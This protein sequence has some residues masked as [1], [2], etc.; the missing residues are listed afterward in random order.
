MF[1]NLTEY[2]KKTVKKKVFNDKNLLGLIT[3]N[4]NVK[5]TLFFSMASKEI[6]VSVKSVTISKIPESKNERIWL[7][8]LEGSLPH[9]ESKESASDHIYLDNLNN[10]LSFF[11]HLLFKVKS[12]KLNDEQI[13]KIQ[14]FV[15]EAGIRFLDRGSAVS[16]R[17]NVLSF[18]AL[19]IAFS[20][21][22]AAAKSM[23]GENLNF[24]NNST[25]FIFT[26]SFLLYFGALIRFNNPFNLAK[27]TELRHLIIE[28]QLRIFKETLKQSSHA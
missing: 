20:G 26:S 7:S 2:K 16:S 21:F 3:D 23:E 11:K 17:K 12:E 4:L 9:L 22:A 10:A 24:K 19:I 6:L 15:Q 25:V 1:V 14:Q 28:L 5:D 18:V 27:K 13:Q 8:L